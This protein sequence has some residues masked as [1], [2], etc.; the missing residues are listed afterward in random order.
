MHK[1]KLFRHLGSVRFLFKNTDTF[2]QQ[3]CIK[4]IKSDKYIHIIKKYF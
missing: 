1:Y 4:L 2:I 3:G